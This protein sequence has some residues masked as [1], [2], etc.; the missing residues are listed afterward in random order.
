MRILRY[1]TDRS[2]TARRRGAA[3][4]EMALVLPI[5]FMVVLGIVEFGR[6]M[7]VGQMVT[8]A[9]REATRLAIV[10]GST[11]SSVEGWIDEFLESSIGV[12][13]ADVDTTITVTAAPGNDDPGN[14]IGNAQSRDLVTVAIA[15]PFDKVSY[16]PGNYLKGKSL[17]AQSAMRHE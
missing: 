2:V 16:L 13:A 8:N 15:V 17:T 7:M 4:L 14:E 6:A 11:N 9:A 5:F 10:D 12:T 3:V 1:S